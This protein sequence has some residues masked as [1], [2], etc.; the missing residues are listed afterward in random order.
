MYFSCMLHSNWR[1]RNT[2]E[3][4]IMGIVN[5]LKIWRIKDCWER[6]IWRALQSSYKY[7]RGTIRG[8]NPNMINGV[9]DSLMEYHV[10]MCQ[11]WIES[12]LILTHWHFA[13]KLS[14]TVLWFHAAQPLSAWSDC[15]FQSISLC[16]FIHVTPWPAG[17]SQMFL[18]LWS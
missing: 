16:H 1:A 12:I 13:K 2:I 10:G 7:L 15:Y 14:E 8:G 3:L 17:V 4:R 6:G 18:L 9:S 11:R 5:E